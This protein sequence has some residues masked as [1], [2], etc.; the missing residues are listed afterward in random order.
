[1]KLLVLNHKMNIEYSIL[2]NYIKEL[3]NI[4]NNN[5][6]LVVCPSDIYL[7]KFKEKAVP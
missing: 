1:M 7:L 4:K 5:I 2:D 3:S 6:K